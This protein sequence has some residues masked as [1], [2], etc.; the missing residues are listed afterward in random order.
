MPADHLSVFLAQRHVTSKVRRNA[1]L[2][3]LDFEPL[4]QGLLAID[5]TNG[6]LGR[7]LIVVADEAVAFGATAL[8][9]SHNA[10]AHNCAQL[11][12][13]EEVEEVE[14]APLVRQVE[15]EQIRPRRSLLVQTLSYEIDCA[16]LSTLALNSLREAIA[17]ATK[18]I[19]L[20]GATTSTAVVVIIA[21]SS[22]ARVPAVGLIAL[23]LLDLLCSESRVRRILATVEVCHNFLAFLRV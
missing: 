7:L 13:V 5:L 6:F 12:R 19:A 11:E 4:T 21:A 20:V 14:V 1:S 16:R 17:N 8:L 23:L 18:G 2:L 22:A 9:I 10:D 3:K 15:D